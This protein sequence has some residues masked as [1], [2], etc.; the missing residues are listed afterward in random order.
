MAQKQAEMKE[1]MMK[2]MSDKIKMSL[3]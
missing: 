3:E 2:A 1:K